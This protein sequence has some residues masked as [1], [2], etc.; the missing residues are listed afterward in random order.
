MRD[1]VR[2]IV[3]GYK[4]LK[5]EGQ[6]EGYVVFSGKDPDTREVV[7]IK[8]L[9]RL[10]E[11]DPQIAKR[12]EGLARTIRQLNHPNI[13]S[14]RKVG[15]ESGLPYLVTRALEKAYPLTARLDQPWAV[16]AAADLA[17]QVGMALEH[18]YNKGLVH[19]SLTPDDIVVQDDGRIL[20]NNL[21]LDE[22][23]GLVGAEFR[24]AASPYLAP[25]RAG[26]TPA[27]ARADV[28]SLAAVLYQLLAGRAPQVVQGQVLP[29]GRFNPDV[30]PAMDEVVVKALSPNAQ[31]RYPDV[32]TFLAALGSVTLVPGKEQDRA[33][34][35]TPGGRCPRC[36]ADKQTG[37]FCRKCG[38]RLEQQEEAEGEEAPRPMRVEDVVLDEPIQ[39]TRIDVGIVEVG[40]G[41]EVQ[42]TVIA[43][44]MQVATGELQGEF[45]EPLQMPE[46]DLGDLWPHMG[47]RVPV[48]VPKP[49]PM[50]EIDWA[51]VAPP[52]PEV[53]K[54]EDTIPDEASD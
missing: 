53:P 36:G 41:I 25:E 7:S 40:H 45:P 21:G 26:G 22:L 49:P 20:V 39:I 31:T 46:L 11:Q 10:L 50:P 42:D 29:P 12:F 23:L 38:L 16:D 15:E 6:D 27:D 48:A 28:Y 18:A 14:V 17:M 24:Q 3:D 43:Q 51:E 37:R 35:V 30:P 1:L 2:K 32:K 44:P 9:P 5:L 19:G 8:I 4:S 34:Q 54:I 47:D 13:V 33:Q 52:M